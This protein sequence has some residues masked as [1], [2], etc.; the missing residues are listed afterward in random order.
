MDGGGG[1]GGGGIEFGLQFLFELESLLNDV[2]EEAYVE[3]LSCRTLQE[4]RQVVA[5]ADAKLL[6]H[7]QGHLP[8]ERFSE[9]SVL[10]FHLLHCLSRQVS[11][12]RRDST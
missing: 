5:R 6:R 10:F 12:E 4:G 1:G 3:L 8:N 7:I 9:V 2:E 11:T